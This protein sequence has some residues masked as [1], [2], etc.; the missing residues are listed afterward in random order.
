MFIKGT[1]VAMASIVQYNE[2][3][4]EEVRLYYMKKM[5]LTHAG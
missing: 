4:E 5:N 2:W 3:L 1:D